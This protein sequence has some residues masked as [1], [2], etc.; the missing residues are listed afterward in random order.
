MIPKIIHQIY[1]DFSNNNKP[2]PDKWK[3]M[4]ETL[5]N[6]HKDFEYILWNKESCL[7]LLQNHYP[8]FINIYE[9]YEYPIQKCDAIRPFILHHYG[10][11]YLDM[12]ITCIKNIY[13]Y[14]KK[15]GVYILESAHLGLTNS[16][17]AS[18]KNHPFWYIIMLQLVKNNQKKWYYF[19]NHWYI[20]KSTGPY[21]IT[22]SF[23]KYKKNDIY[24][25]S[26]NNFNPCNYCQ[27]KCNI[28]KKKHIY[29]YTI[30]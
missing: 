11:I 28:N 24:K 26:K 23:K 9:N 2:I 18:I 17:M 30:N 6:N 15:P 19:S 3:K 16:F 22:N 5:Q 25:I 20:M 13:E 27:K 14:F 4:S 7:K 21:L 29:C 10:G 1:W 8:W 12:D